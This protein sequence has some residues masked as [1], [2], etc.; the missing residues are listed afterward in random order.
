MTI[1]P[2]DVRRLL[3]AADSDSLLVLIEG[4]A[5]VIAAAALDSD[6]FRGAL[7]VT[8]RQK[9]LDQVGSSTPS[10]HEL[11]EQAGILDAAISTLGG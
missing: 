5:E 2:N 6:D 11:A 1:S 10:E 4:R 9:L 3:D 8:S 7:T